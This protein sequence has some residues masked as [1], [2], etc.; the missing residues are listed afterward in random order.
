MCLFLEN[1][2]H[3]SI[4]KESIKNIDETERDLTF[5]VLINMMTQYN[6]TIYDLIYHVI[7]YIIY[8]IG[9]TFKS[10]FNLVVDLVLNL[11]LILERKEFFEHIRK[12]LFF[13]S[14]TINKY[15]QKV[16][17]QM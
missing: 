14:H 9:D 16:K 5:Y 10:I 13:V 7:L 11:F 6:M 15:F 2:G 17:S 1:W 3:I 4:Q 12:T 8:I